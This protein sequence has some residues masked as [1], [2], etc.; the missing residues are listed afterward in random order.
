MLF[1]TLAPKVHGAC[2]NRVAC[3]GDSLTN[4]VDQITT[5]CVHSTTGLQASMNGVYGT[6]PPSIG[7]LSSLHSLQLWSS[8]LSGT[9]PPSLGSLTSLTTLTLSDGGF[10]GVLPS[11]FGQLVHIVYFEIQGTLLSGTLPPIFESLGQARGSSFLTL[12]LDSSRFSGPIPS[13]WSKGRISILSLGH[14]KLRN[15]TI[16]AGQFEYGHFI[17]GNGKSAVWEYSAQ[18]GQ[19]AF[20]RRRCVQQSLVRFIAREFFALVYQGLLV[21]RV[22]S[23][24]KQAEWVHSR[25]LLHRQ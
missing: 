1:S 14:N 2:Q 7:S 20:V 13:N 9:L 11:S 8:S 12:V 15:N 5:E 16:R 22:N 19:S 25:I 6:I 10:T 17:F 21:P 23:Q 24:R 3:S 4:C 18:F